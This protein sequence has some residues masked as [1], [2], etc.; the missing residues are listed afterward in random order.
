MQNS[1]IRFR[2]KPIETSKVFLQVLSCFFISLGWDASIFQ[3]CFLPG[4][5]SRAQGE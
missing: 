1:A 3:G 2:K 4:V 5:H